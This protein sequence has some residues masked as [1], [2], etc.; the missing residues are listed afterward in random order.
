MIKKF[1]TLAMGIVVSLGL[2]GCATYKPQVLPS[3]ADIVSPSKVDDIDTRKGTN[4]KNLSLIV[5]EV[6]RY[7]PDLRAMRQDLNI[8]D[9]LVL[10]A[11]LLPD[12]SVGL[13]IATPLG[14]EGLYNALGAGIGWSL[15]S[16]FTRSSDVNRA[17]LERNVTIA[18]YDWQVRLTIANALVLAGRLNSLQEQRKIA[19]RTLE[20]SQ[21]LSEVTGQKALVFDETL[22][23]SNSR[24]MMMLDA[25]DTQAKIN[26]QIAST[27]YELNYQLG[28]APSE[29][30]QIVPFD[31]DGSIPDPKVLFEQAVKK[32]DDLI[33]RQY[34]YQSSDTFYKRNLLAQFPS[35]ALTLNWSSDTSKIKTFGPSVTFDLPLWNRNQGGIALSKALRDK[36]KESYSAALERAYSDIFSLSDALKRNQILYAKAKDESTMNQK[37][38]E[39]LH[40]ALKKGDITLI[41]YTAKM[42]EINTKELWMIGLSQSIFE[43]RIALSLAS[44]SSTMLGET[45]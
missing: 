13:S 12:P 2:V 38:T 31:L 5:H 41:D 22:I 10:G 44:G 11:G 20:L 30:I 14:G 29:K 3:V 16:L 25:L 43:Q 6:A 8:S 1:N 32:R 21:R 26:D 7:N 33:A 28:L 36:E 35:F 9:A 18:S 17:Q 15:G 24:K 23:M 19:L 27:Q 34:A 45:K 4:T 40:K 37:L 42:N 39:T